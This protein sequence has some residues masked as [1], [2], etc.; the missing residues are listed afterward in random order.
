MNTQ[1]QNIIELN[2]FKFKKNVNIN[3]SIE[4]KQSEK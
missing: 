4:K 2:K 1:I 3:K